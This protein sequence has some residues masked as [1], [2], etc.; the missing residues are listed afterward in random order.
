MVKLP[1][2]LAGCY[3]WY[4]RVTVAALNGPSKMFKYLDVDLKY[5]FSWM[6]MHVGIWTEEKHSLAI[7]MCTARST[8]DE[9][10]DCVPV[11]QA[12]N[13]GTLKMVQ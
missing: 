2:L 11:L 12:A 1:V 5:V 7:E 10:S 4:T 13:A 8:G 9:I 6:R 3:E